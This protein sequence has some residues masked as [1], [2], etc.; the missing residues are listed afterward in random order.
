MH[1]A[2]ARSSDPPPP[3]LSESSARPSFQS[4]HTESSAG[5]SLRSTQT[6]GAGPLQGQPSLANASPSM[7]LGLH[8]EQRGSLKKHVRGLKQRLDRASLDLQVG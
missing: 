6:G 7:R 4:T 8:V 2:T 1:K 5:P 3:R